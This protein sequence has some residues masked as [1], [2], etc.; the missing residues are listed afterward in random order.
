MSYL[1]RVCP[2][3]GSERVYVCQ[4]YGKRRTRFL[5]CRACGYRFS[6]RRGTPFFNL[7]T[8]EAKIAKAIRYIA[9]GH[10][11]RSTAKK[12]GVDKNTLC[13]ILERMRPDG[14][15]TDYLLRVL[16]MDEETLEKFWKAVGRRKKSFYLPHTTSAEEKGRSS[17]FVPGV[18]LL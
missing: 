17:S 5:R 7:K 1:D 13:R 8:D 10:S 6:E 3:C 2:K 12:L 14:R 11:I 4:V 16:R 15:T 9:Q 18:H